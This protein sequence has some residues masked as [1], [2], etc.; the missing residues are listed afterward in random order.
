MVSVDT[1]GSL[2]ARGTPCCW[3]GRPGVSA[4]ESTDAGG[5]HALDAERDTGQRDEQQRDADA[6]RGP[7]GGGD[8]V[9]A[10]GQEQD[11]DGD[12]REEAV[13]EAG[14]P[15]VA[16]VPDE[17]RHRH[18]GEQYR[19]RVCREREPDHDGEGQRSVRYR[20]RAGHGRPANARG[21]KRSLA[22]SRR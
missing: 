3:P 2:G 21:E 18:A 10:R 16:R 5:E 11:R 12:P 19:R 4:P 8:D 1:L 15:P 14:E 9:V 22:V 20:T 7:L 17:E 13:A 6:G